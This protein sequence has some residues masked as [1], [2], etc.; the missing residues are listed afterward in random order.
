MPASTLAT[1]LAF[2]IAL[3][4]A[5]GVGARVTDGFQA[6]TLESARR[7]EALRAPRA[8]THLAFATP[9]GE[10]VQLQRYAGQWVLVDF[11]YT[12]CQTLCTSLGSVYAQLQQRLGG[13]IASGHVRLLSV[14]FDPARDAAAQLLAYRA[15]HSV[16]ALGWDMARPS[17]EDLQ[18][19]FGSFGVVVIPDGAGGFAHNAAIHVVNP[20]GRLQ[21][22]ANVGDTEEAIRHVR[23][24]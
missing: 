7:L 12:G 22:I 13:E 5:L 18:D 10:R 2:A 20:E 6:F 9:E 1:A 23:P 24:R 17:L 21:A 16:S 4:T 15:R 11:I 14:S 3:A 8:V 19:W